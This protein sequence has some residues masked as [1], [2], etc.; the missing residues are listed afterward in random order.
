MSIGNSGQHGALHISWHLKWEKRKNVFHARRV[1]GQCDRPITWQ[2]KLFFRHSEELSKDGAWKVCNRNHEA[3][4]IHRVNKKMTSVHNWCAAL[5][6]SSC[7]HVLLLPSAAIFCH[8]LAITRS[9]LLL[10]IANC[11]GLMEFY[12]M[13]DCK[14]CVWIELRAREGSVV[15]ARSE[16]R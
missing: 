1:T 11:G 15:Y 14:G 13:A 12:C 6:T 8:F 7:W 9:L 16:R 5:R 3:P 2:T 10:S 4:S